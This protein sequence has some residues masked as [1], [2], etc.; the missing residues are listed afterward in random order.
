MTILRNEEEYER[1]R[2]AGRLVAEALL[3]AGKL[4]RPGVSTLSID[5]KIEELIRDNGAEP[6][7][8]GYKG[9]PAT[10]CASR[11]EVVV[12]GIP[13][14]KV[15]LREGD[16]LGVDVG[17]KLNGFYADAAR[18]FPVGE[19][20]ERASML[21]EATRKSLEEGTRNAVS[22][23]RV[24]DISIAIQK[25][26]QSSGFKEVRAFVGHG[27]GRN[28]HELP[29]VPNWGVKGR[30][31]VLEEGLVLAIEPMFNEGTRE[32]EIMPDGW[33]AVTADRKLSAHFENTV[34]VGKS[35][36]EVVTS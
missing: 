26:A 15:I 10:I 1:L 12:H 32:V 21:V 22:G 3:L 36:V 35:N 25:V 29:E 28:L 19:I 24:S 6:A 23:N 33:T 14:E 27:T 2:A 34:I 17:V 20:S 4:V 31:K 8:K 18:T 11:N 30:G 5:T 7:F 16:I 9:Y 13:S